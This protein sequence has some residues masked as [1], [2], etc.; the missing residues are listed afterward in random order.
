MLYNGAIRFLKQAQGRVEQQQ[1]ESCHHHILKTQDI[2]T[3]LMSTLDLNQGQ[4]AENLYQL[5]DYMY[6]RL[7]EANIRKDS[8]PLQEVEQLLSEETWTE[9]IKL[10]SKKMAKTIFNYSKYGAVTSINGYY[11]PGG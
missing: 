11:Y 2:L 7:I 6:S 10:P 4:I 3:E 8:Q 5:Y 9:A 1:L